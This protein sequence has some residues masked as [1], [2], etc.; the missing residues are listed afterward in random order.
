MANNIIWQEF[1]G[2]SDSLFSGVKNSFYRMVGIN[3]TSQPGSI[4]VHQ[5]LA[6]DSGSTITALCRNAITLSNTGAKLWFSYTDGKIWHELSGIYTLVYTTAPAAGNAGCLGAFEYN[7][8]VYWATQSRLHRIPIA[9]ATATAADWTANVTADWQTFSKTDSEFHPMKVQNATLW[10]GDGNLVAS[11]NSS[12]TFTASALN[13]VA[14]LRCKTFFPFDIDLVVG[15]IITTNINECQIIRW[16]TIQTSWQYSETVWENGINAFLWTGTTLL[17]QAGTQGNW[18]YYDGVKLQPY[19]RI[20]GTW[21]P[22]SYGD[23]S[24]NAVGVLLNIPI[25]GFS[26]GSGNPAD[27]GIYSLGSYSKDY[28]KVISGPDFPLS[29]G[30][31]TGITIGAIIVDGSNLY[32]AWQDGSDFG[33]D[34]LNYSAKYASAYLETLRITPSVENMSTTYRIFANYQSLPSGTDC[35]FKYKK[36]NDTSYT[37]LTSVNDTVNAR[38]YAEL[39]IDHRAFQARIEFTVSGNTAPI[40]EAVGIELVN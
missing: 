1:N 34:K 19:K 35:T 14:P 17:A 37:T 6:K 12:A 31:V 27:Q 28:T 29:T 40:L 22:T 21:S 20:P 32:A 36:N 10:I 8:Y 24:P 39:T 25:F 13:M 4:T 15:T 26:N 11:V 30:N 5:A 3:R 16:D 33:I 7:T 2:I 18:Y 9:N 38:L 23:V